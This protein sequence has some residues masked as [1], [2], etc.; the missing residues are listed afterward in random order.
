MSPRPFTGRHMLAA[1][2]G[3]FG[4]VIAVNVTMAW[5]AS[6]TFGGTVVD[7]SYVASQSFN[8]WLAAGRAQRALGWS[9]ALD[10]DAARHVRVKAQ[11]PEGAVL[12][13]TATHPLGRIAEQRLA[14]IAMG[15]GGWRSAA[16]LPAGRFLVRIEVR[17]A[18]QRA[19]FDDDVPA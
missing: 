10:L 5:F 1:M 16:P 7:N 4:V 17:A 6:T 13:G 14:F 11:I 9:V 18:G 2:L 19:A 12:R 8:R 15:D 3:F